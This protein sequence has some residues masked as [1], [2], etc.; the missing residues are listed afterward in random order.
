[1]QPM[2]KKDDEHYMKNCRSIW[3]LSGFSE[4]LEKCLTGSV[5]LYTSMIFLLIHKMDLEE[6]DQRKLLL[7]LIYKVY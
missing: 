1:M 7:S 3:M 4:I 5:L 6:V 2:V